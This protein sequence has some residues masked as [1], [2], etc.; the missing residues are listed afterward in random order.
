MLV[1]VR[2]L[3]MVLLLRVP[4]EIRHQNMSPG[5]GREVECNTEKQKIQTVHAIGVVQYV[6]NVIDG[7]SAVS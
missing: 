5:E 3:S 4:R 2:A 1:C 6:G 7:A